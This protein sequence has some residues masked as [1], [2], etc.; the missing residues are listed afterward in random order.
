MLTAISY[1]LNLITIDFNWPTRPQSFIQKKP[2][3]ETTSNMFHQSQ[4]PPT[5][6]T[7]LFF[8]FLAKNV[9]TT[10]QLHSSHMLAK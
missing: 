10:A 6:C 4:H 8:V 7:N 3:Q 1:R 2:Q 5:F 9:Q